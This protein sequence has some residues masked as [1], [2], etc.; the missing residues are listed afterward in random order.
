MRVTR[1]ALAAAL[2]LVPA[3]A[4]AQTFGQIKWGGIGNSFPASFRYSNGNTI[5]VYAGAAYRASLKISSSNPYLPPHGTTAF[6]PTVDIFCVD[7]LH[8]ANTSSAG[9]D[10]WFTRLGG[11]DPLT[12]TRNSDATQYLKAAWLITKMDALGFTTADKDTRADLHAAIWNMMSGQ[13]VSVKH[14]STFTSTGISYW[15]TQANLFWNDGTVNAGEW[16]VVTDACVASG[17]TAGA[18]HD[19]VPADQCAQE[20][21]THNV[22]PEPAT[23]ILLSTGVLVLLGVGGVFR[24]G[25][26]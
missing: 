10:A 25:I 1:L 7:F 14:G 24:R 19:N 16:T 6:G 15:Q 23:V 21:L 11:S 2:V 4:P 18:G 5:S 13:P 8:T 20:F 22:V 3:A 9:Y 17:G 12:A 26:A